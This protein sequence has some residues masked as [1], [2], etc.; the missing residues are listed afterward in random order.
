MNTI[1]KL[2]FP[3][4][5][6]M[7]ERLFKKIEDGTNP[8]GTL[9][10]AA[11]GVVGEAIELRDFKD[12]AHFIEEAGDLEFYLEALKQAI[13]ALNG[14]V[15]EAVIFEADEGELEYNVFGNI[16][17]AGGDIVDFAKKSWV[18]RKPLH[19]QELVNSAEIVCQHLNW[20]YNHFGTTREEVL[21]ENQVKLIGP[22][23]R[24]RDGFYS[25]A[26]AIARADK[27]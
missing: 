17:S 14:S 5:P 20:L 21:Y 4:Y 3:S 7:I 23:G 26:A 9:M 8:Y 1:A 6:V 2:E 24:F 12:K 25:D 18:Y 13:F 27:A 19:S 22:E 10:H 16:V 11:V 15:P